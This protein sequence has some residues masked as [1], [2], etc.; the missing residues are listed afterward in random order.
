MWETGIAYQLLHSSNVDA[1]Q[2][3]SATVDALGRFEDARD[4]GEARIIQ[5]IFEAAFA[6]AAFRDVFM[7]VEPA[8]TF[9]LGVIGMDAGDAIKA[10][11]FRKLLDHTFIVARLAEVI[12]RGEKVA[13]VKTDTES[14]G[15]LSSVYH[16][17]D[18]T[19]FVTEG[20]SL[21]GG[22]F[23]QHARHKAARRAMRFVE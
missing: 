9:A 5:Q 17:P 2:I 16:L 22:R 4:V 1:I 8:A 21:T 19:K 10:D 12:A 3:R 13:G 6:D 18:L 14:L 11:V 23:E 15:L 7:A 20:G